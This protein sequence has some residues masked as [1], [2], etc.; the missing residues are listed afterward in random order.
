VQVEYSPFSLDIESPQIDLLKTCRELGVAVVA[1]S[2]LGRGFLTGSIRSRSDF[3]ANDF[4]AMAPRFNEEN[5][6]K[7]LKLVDDLKAIADSKGCTA[8]QLVLAFLM[9]QGDD[10]IPIPGTTRPKNFD[11]NMASLDV[12]LSPDELSK[13][14]K[15]LDETEVHGGRY[16]AAFSAALYV[17][18][19]PLE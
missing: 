14:R 17:D 15:L 5:F 3:D 10:I 16:P 7:N 4:R 11:E 1:Y 2:P 18:T 13:I 6:P 9:A 8:S 19:V 12:K